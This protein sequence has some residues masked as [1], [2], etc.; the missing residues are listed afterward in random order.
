L[1]DSWGNIRCIVHRNT[2]LYGDST[3]DFSQVSSRLFT[4]FRCCWP[5]SSARIQTAREVKIN[6]EAV[7]RWMSNDE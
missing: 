1:Q 4:T 2:R 7:A 6:H 3:I 5:V